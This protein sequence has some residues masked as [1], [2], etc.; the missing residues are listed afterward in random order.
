MFSVVSLRL[1]LL[2]QAIHTNV[3]PMGIFFNEWVFDS[4]PV[5]LLSSAVGR[6]VGSYAFACVRVITV[7]SHGFACFQVFGYVL[8]CLAPIFFAK[9]G[10]VHFW[11][12]FDPTSRGD[13]SIF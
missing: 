5:N 7:G 6:S 3:T 12:S 1:N 9:H 4:T 11:N 10:T 13:P 2:M 8:C